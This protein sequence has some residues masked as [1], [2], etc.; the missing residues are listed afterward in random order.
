MMLVN[1]RKSCVVILPQDFCVDMSSRQQLLSSIIG[2][3]H[4]VARS[5]F[6][7]DDA[8]D[9]QRQLDELQERWR[10]LTHRVQ[11]RQ[12]RLDSRASLWRQYEVRVGR[13]EEK[14]VSSFFYS[15]SG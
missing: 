1:F 5:S 4:E 9:V 6:D 3:A 12:T 14:T 8:R 11:E 13:K 10:V 15:V 7:V 2:D